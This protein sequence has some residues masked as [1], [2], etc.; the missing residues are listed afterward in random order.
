[1][2]HFDFT[3][4]FVIGINRPLTFSFFFI[5]HHNRQP[6]NESEKILFST[7]FIKDKRGVFE[8]VKSSMIGHG[9]PF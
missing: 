7:H 5:N 9:T 3:F 4:V 8:F 1:M 2:G 6:K